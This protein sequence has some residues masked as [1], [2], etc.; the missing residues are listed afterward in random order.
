MEHEEDEPGGTT[1]LPVDV[2]LEQLHCAFV[3]SLSFKFAKTLVSKCKYWVGHRMAYDVR[4]ER[5]DAMILREVDCVAGTHNLRVRRAVAATDVDKATPI[6]AAF[7]D[8]FEPSR[9]ER[10]REKP[11]PPD[12]GAM[13]DELIDAM[14]WPDVD[15]VSGGSCDSGDASPDESDSVGDASVLSGIEGFSEGDGDGE[16]GRTDD[17]IELPPEGASATPEP[18]GRE[19]Q[20]HW[21]ECLLE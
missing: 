8:L 4:P 14:P 3:E 16:G 5:F 11:D 10:Q 21:E 17:E 2:Q 1:Q 18:L 7:D 19:I 20:A 13:L 9:N 15:A 6:E 12:A